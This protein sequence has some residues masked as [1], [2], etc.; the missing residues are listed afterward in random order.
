MAKMTGNL[1]LKKTKNL[2]EGHWSVAEA[3]DPLSLQEVERLVIRVSNFSRLANQESLFTSNI[4]QSLGALTSTHFERDS[5]DRAL[6]CFTVPE[7]AK[8]D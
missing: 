6:T 3:S 2:A 7:V 8:D 1:G 5:E 4:N